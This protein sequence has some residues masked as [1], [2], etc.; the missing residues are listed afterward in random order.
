MPLSTTIAKGF[1]VK[2]K[3]YKI[4]LSFICYCLLLIVIPPAFAKYSYSVCLVFSLCYTRDPLIDPLSG[5]PLIKK[6][7]YIFAVS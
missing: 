4:K 6:L 3:I 1:H 5:K 2:Y 7:F